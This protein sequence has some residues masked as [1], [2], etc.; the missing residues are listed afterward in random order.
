MISKTATD[1]EAYRKKVFFTNSAREGW[2][3]ILK[4][5]RPES[6]VLLPAYIGIT[7]REGSG[8]YDPIS[9]LNLPHDFYLLN[10]DLSISK[11]EIERCISKNKYDLILLVH[12][13]GFK[14]NNI[15]EIVSLC[16]KHNLIV[17]EDCAHLYS[18]NLSV[19]TD[20][21]SFGDYVFY[22]LHKNF[23]FKNGGLVVQNHMNL[24][25][26]S[27]N[28]I[29]FE[30][31]LSYQLLQYDAEKIASKRQENYKILDAEIK[32]IEGVYPLRSLTQKDIPHTYP[33][34]VEN[35]LRER[36]YFWL[37]EKN[38]TVIALYYRLIV[39]LNEDKYD[40]MQKISNSILNLPIHQDINKNDI[41]NLAEVI[42][43]F[44]GQS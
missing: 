7:D 19:F 17:V 6:K 42:K 4:T 15:E 30:D 23:P 26:L 14:I 37:V 22:S 8:I 2:E 13:F 32:G 33:I 12:Y 44:Y 43:Q 11:D 21:G 16:K 36:L 41:K 40:E 38:M 5:L 1:P 31:K 27:T 39:P 34:I 9:K 24:V 25:T 28:E 10:N 20:A 35:D 18:Y 3:L 29:Q